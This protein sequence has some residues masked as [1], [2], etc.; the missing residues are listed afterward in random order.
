MSIFTVIYAF[1]VP[2]AMYAFKL[3]LGTPPPALPGE[4]RQKNVDFTP[5]LIDG[6]R[7]WWPIAVH[8]WLT[9]AIAESGACL[10]RIFS[11]PSYSASGSIGQ[12]TWNLCPSVEAFNPGNRPPV[13]AWMGCLVIFTG[14]MLRVW[15]M[16]SLGK[17]FTWEVSIRPGHKL[18]TGG[19]YT[20]VRHPSYLGL[21]LIQTGQ[22]MFALTGR[23]FTSECL[24]WK[25]STSFHLFQLLVLAQAL[26]TYATCWRRAIVEDVLLK[27][28]FGKEWVDW[29]SRTRY[30]IL[31]GIF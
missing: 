25:F 6:Y 28:Q 18:Y 19:P 24:G 14:S 27:K 5:T 8:I 17:F 4:E 7:K 10:I 1:T 11:D 20:F 2:V 16:R 21:S 9:V 29:A 12:M 3:G 15:S 31:P 26:P 23:T 13:L 22:L 30:R